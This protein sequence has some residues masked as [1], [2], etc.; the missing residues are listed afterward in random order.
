MSKPRFTEW[1]KR[2]GQQHW[3]LVGNK[4][5]ETLCGKP[6]LGGNYIY[7]NA[8]DKTPCSECRDARKRIEQ[9]DPDAV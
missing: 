2:L 5:S 7:L 3:H 9:E 4:R 8:E 1:T 6:M